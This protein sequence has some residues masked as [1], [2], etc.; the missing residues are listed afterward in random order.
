MKY[1]FSILLFTFSLL[2]FSCKKEKVAPAAN[3]AIAAPSN[4]TPTQQAELNQLIKLNPGVPIDV[5]IGLMGL[6]DNGN[7]TG[8]TNAN[9]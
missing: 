6:I 4:F 3:T 1:L 9:D 7:T 2:L 8:V 5:L